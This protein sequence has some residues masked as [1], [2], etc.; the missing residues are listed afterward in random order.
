ML[1]IVVGLIL[2][3]L[4]A[5]GM[6][7]MS[8]ASETY[9]ECFV[10]KYLEGSKLVL[11]FADLTTSEKEDED[12]AT[13]FDR[14]KKDITDYLTKKST[15]ADYVK[16]MSSHCS[17]EGYE[18]NGEILAFSETMKKASVY[19][20]KDFATCMLGKVGEKVAPADT[21][22]PKMWQT[23]L[24]ECNVVDPPMPIPAL[25]E[26]KETNELKKYFESKCENKIGKSTKG[27][28]FCTMQASEFEKLAKQE[29]LE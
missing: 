29:A 10:D 2:V 15:D 19:K 7:K 14:H 16:K 1:L 6:K 28:A 8:S 22:D 3:L 5:V 4:F 9:G 13:R 12:A 18:D 25:V 20:F 23:I 24:K 11:E 26:D 17:T 21:Y 27:E